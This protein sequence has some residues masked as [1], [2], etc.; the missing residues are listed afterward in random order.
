MASAASIWF[1][2]EHLAKHGCRKVLGLSPECAGLFAFAYH[3]TANALHLCDL[4]FYR[5]AEGGHASA[6]EHAGRAAEQRRALDD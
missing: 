3:V 4:A 1:C 6:V 5:V 2:R